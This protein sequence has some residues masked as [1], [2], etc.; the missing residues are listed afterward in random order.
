MDVSSFLSERVVFVVLRI[1][2]T[3]RT[4]LSVCTGCCHGN[5]EIMFRT[6]WIC[7]KKD[8]VRNARIKLWRVR[9]AIV[10]VETQ[11]SYVG[12]LLSSI[13]QYRNI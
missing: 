4:R 13:Q 10:A 5:T 3:D 1:T 12:V 6:T 2:C 9:V 8:K 11:H 7:S